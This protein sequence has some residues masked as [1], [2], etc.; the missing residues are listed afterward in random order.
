MDETFV[1]TSHH[2]PKSWQCDDIALNVPIGKSERYIIVHA[3]TKD[4][5]IP[6]T[7]DAS[8]GK[9]SS[10]DYHTNMN[11]EKIEKW[12]IYN[13]L[14]NIPANSV[15]FFDNVPYHKIQED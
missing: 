7:E 13:L 15:I 8:K 6:N 1:N 14:P 12:V 9:N 4:G 5:F 11:R 3:S 2:V 10:S